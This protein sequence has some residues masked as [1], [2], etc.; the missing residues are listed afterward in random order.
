MET[1]ELPE[2]PKIEALEEQLKAKDEEIAKLKANVSQRMEDEDSLTKEIEKYKV[3]LKNTDNALIERGKEN[4]RL[5]YMLEEIKCTYHAD[6]IWEHRL[7]TLKQKKNPVPT[8]QLC[9]RCMKYPGLTFHTPD[10]TWMAVTADRY[11][12]LC[13]PCFVDMADERLIDWEPGLLIYSESVA[14]LRKTQERVSRGEYTDEGLTEW[15][16]KPSFYNPPYIEGK[17]DLQNGG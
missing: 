10:E 7:P 3:V 13:L 15:K 1:N 2:L 11:Q 12:H 4:E 14:H 8:R 16:T 9:K 5:R 17:T 6:I